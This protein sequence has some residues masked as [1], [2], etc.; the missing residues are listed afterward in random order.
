MSSE[1]SDFGPIYRNRPRVLQANID[2]SDP[3]STV[4]AL[5]QVGDHLVDQRSIFE[6]RRAILG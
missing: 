5:L 1:S 3:D 6:P 2:T 4:R